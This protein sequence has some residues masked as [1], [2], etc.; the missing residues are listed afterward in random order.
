MQAKLLEEKR[1]RELA[2]AKDR[3]ASRMLSLPEIQ[4]NLNQINRDLVQEEEAK[5][6]K[7]NV[8]HASGLDEVISALSISDQ[9]EDK[10][11]ERRRKA[12]YK[13]FEEARMP[14][15]RQDNP[16]LRYSQLK[17]LLWKE[18]QNHPDNPMRE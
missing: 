11:P 8:V 10:H 16:D 18:W 1:L 5:Y 13:A 17:E 7:G 3:E 6:G 4:P 14:T 2:E 9:K 15:L 12:A